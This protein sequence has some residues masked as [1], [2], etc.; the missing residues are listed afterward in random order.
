M[1]P[2]NDRSGSYRVT[3]SDP[4]PHTSS[5][6]PSTSLININI[7]LLTD[8][9]SPQN[10]LLATLHGRGERLTPFSLLYSL[11]RFPLSLFL[12]TPRILYEATRL[13]YKR[14]LDVYPRPELHSGA[15]ED[16][17]L[18]PVAAMVEPGSVL[19]QTATDADRYARSVVESYLMERCEA[20]KVRVKLQPED[21]AVEAAMFGTAG[22][23]LT[24]TYASALFF[25]DLLLAP[26]ASLALA[27]AD[28]RW[29]VSDIELFTR[30]LAADSKED[31][32]RAARA[33]RR[34]RRHYIKWLAS[35]ALGVEVDTPE[36]HPLDGFA[37][38]ALVRH[39][40]GRLIAEKLGYYVFR[41]TR[42]R[43]VEGTE[44]WTVLARRAGDD[45]VRV[46]DTIRK[47]AGGIGS[48][49]RPS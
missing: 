17:V 27:M 31:L 32:N 22:E 6:F 19:W 4:L 47:R 49:I 46:A 38:W 24:I 20:L 35:F 26:S 5:S 9:S 12:T 25:S 34:L 8:D 30:F 41:L 43:F 36:R 45:R 1:S 18:N 42:A 3:I 2:F 21:R 10:K 28:D 14:K 15:Q 44:P 13:H 48:I 33:A 11:V 39:L 40:I 37:T 16:G 29:R 7:L 23:E